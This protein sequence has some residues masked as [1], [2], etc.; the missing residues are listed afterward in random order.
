[1][2]VIDDTQ[3]SRNAE[4]NQTPEN[5]QMEIND[6]ND[7]QPS[8]LSVS[9]SV[10]GMETVQTAVKQSIDTFH[11]NTYIHL[12]DCCKSISNKNML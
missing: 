7:G 10:R 9:S 4:A 3:T 6:D 11:H 12:I 1:M 5:E 8:E 2:E